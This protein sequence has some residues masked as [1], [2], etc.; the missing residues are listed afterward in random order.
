MKFNS[1]LGRYLSKQIIVTFLLVLVTIMGVI[2]MFDSIEALRRI[3]GRDDTGMSY[4]VKY[5]LTKLPETIDK[6]LPFVMMVAAMIT[7]WKVSKSN[8]YVIIRASGVSAWGFLRPV[9]MAV[10]LVGVIN[11]ALFNPISAKMYE[12][13]ATLKYRFITRDPTAMLFSSKGL[14]IREAEGPDKVLVVQAKS[15]RQEDPKTLSMRDISILEMD[16]KGQILRRIEGLVGELKKK[17][18]KLRGVRIYRTGEKT[19]ELP[20]YE[21]QTTITMQRIKENFVDPDA[22][23]FW[24]L[25]DTI[26]FYETSGF[27]AARHQMRY[28]SLWAS[29]FL[30]VAMVLVSA[31]FSL[32]PS[33]RQGG[34]MLMIVTGVVTG[35]MVYFSSQLIYAFGLNGYIPVVMAVWSPTVIV[36]LLAVTVLLH[37]E[38]R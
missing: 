3:S 21:Y 15:L 8:E 5:A 17:S 35:F 25:P 31:L 32:R 28:L 29:P 6:V 18:F 9:L 19:E 37:Q 20:F 38:E 2:M 10:F 7:F 23:S 36:T 33:V 24:N 16:Q 12:M 30:L 4:V 27:S 14:W 13:H 11:V 34:V 26:R 22:I 1:I